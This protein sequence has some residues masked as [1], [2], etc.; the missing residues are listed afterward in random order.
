MA[1]ASLA[2]GVAQGSR[3]QENHDRVARASG[4]TRTPPPLGALSPPRTLP[5]PERAVAAR[6]RTPRAS[7]A[8][9]PARPRPASPLRA[10]WAPARS[11]PSASPLRARS[12][13]ARTRHPA[14]AAP[15]RSSEAPRAARPDRRA[16]LPAPRVRQSCPAAD[17]GAL[18]QLQS[19]PVDLAPWF[20]RQPASK[21]TVPAHFPPVTA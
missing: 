14:S 5:A 6:P 16:G 19:Q 7:P 15:A 18:H 20:H 9:R 11:S 2:R 12:A 10:P 1:L 3:F 8:E 4:T 17:L 13:P 21:R